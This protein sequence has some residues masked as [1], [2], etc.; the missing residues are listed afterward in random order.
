MTDKN[1]PTLQDIAAERDWW[2]QEAGMHYRELAQWLRETAR[3]CRLPY[4][5]REL[6]TLARGY[7]MRSDQVTRR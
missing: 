7:E 3:K 1:T 5:K 6:T 4:T 2:S